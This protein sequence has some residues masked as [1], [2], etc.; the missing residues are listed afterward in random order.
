MAA[1]RVPIASNTY[2]L[3]N[4]RDC[5]EMICIMSR[6]LI[7][8]ELKEKLSKYFWKMDNFSF[9]VC[10]ILVGILTFVLACHQ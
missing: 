5:P 8:E 10:N 6:D 1:C 2:A 4:V 3:R 7:S 9:E